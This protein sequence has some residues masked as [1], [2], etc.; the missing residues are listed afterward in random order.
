MYFFFIMIRVTSSVLLTVT[1]LSNVDRA[2]N[3]WHVSTDKLTKG[4]GNQ[5]SIKI[6]FFCPNWMLWVPQMPEMPFH[7][8][9]SSN[10]NLKINYTGHSPKFHSN[11]AA[12]SLTP[13]NCASID[14]SNVTGYRVHCD[15]WHHHVPLVY[16]RNIKHYRTSSTTA[17]II[18]YATCFDLNL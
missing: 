17:F 5:H 15:R 9:H 6:S 18:R 8:D 14:Y 1:S 12:G 4:F 7:Q 10:T 11:T 2:T 3:Y 13:K 16:Q